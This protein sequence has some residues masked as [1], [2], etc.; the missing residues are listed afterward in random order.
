MVETR[1]RGRE[2]GDVAIARIP[3]FV[4]L[5]VDINGCLDRDSS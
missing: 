2:S 5:T 4:C 1:R 3:A